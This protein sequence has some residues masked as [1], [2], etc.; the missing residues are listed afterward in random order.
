MTKQLPRGVRSNNPGNI[1]DDGK[2]PWQGL[3]SPRNDGRFL[4]FV[5]APFGIRAL[6]RTLIVYQDKRRAPDG[7]AIDTVRE[8]INRWAPP[9]ENDTGAY[10]SHV[11][12]RLGVGPNDPV[13]LHHHAV[14]KPLVCAIIAHECSGY[15]YADSVVD[16]GLRLAGVQPPAPSA[17]KDPKVIAAGIVAAATTAQQAVAQA[18]GIWSSLQRMGISPHYVMAALGLAAVAAGAWFLWDRWQRSRQGIA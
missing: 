6:A 11:A 9:T 4:R 17:G 2:T 3:D 18:E 7:S 13:D 15:A 1:E 8:I 5:S 10:V 14:L 12:A 16:E